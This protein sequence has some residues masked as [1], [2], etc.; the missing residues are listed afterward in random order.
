M[1]AHILHI[2]AGRAV[3]GSHCDPLALGSKP[4]IKLERMEHMRMNQSRTRSKWGHRWGI[5]A[6][7]GLGLV[8][9]AACGG[10]ETSPGQPTA[11]AGVGGTPPATAGTPAAAG[12]AAPAGAAGTVATGGRAGTGAAG[13]RA[14][15]AGTAAAGTGS[16]TAGSAAVSAGTGGAAGA[17]G[18][19]GEAGAAGAAGAAGTG[20]G[21]V[22]T[23]GSCLDG[24]T[25]FFAKGK[26][27]FMQMRS[28]MINFWKPMVPAGCK[29]PVI[30][31]ANGTGASCSNYAAS[32]ERMASHGFLAA[33][34]ENANTG[35]GT[36]GLEAL[37]TAVTM[38]PDLVD[39]KFGSTGHSQGGQASFVVLQFA[40]KEFGPDAK[41]AGLAMQPASGFGE[42]PAGGWQSIYRMIKSPML[43]F[44]G[45]GTDGL[46]SQA[47]VQDA[48][49]ELDDGIEAYHWTKQGGAH[50]PVPNGEE[51]QLS[52]AW[53]RWK[54]LGD[55]KACAAFKAIPMMD[56]TWEE[57]AVQNAAPCM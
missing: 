32:L 39:K 47:W 13:A 50:I 43:M 49:T 7:A 14:G 34:Y 33:C 24:D 46:V 29:V 15:T 6:L 23:E 36:Q 55:Q 56:R 17:A 27:Q 37:K 16:G 5:C 18:A 35:A 4:G 9:L 3:R 12:S 52:I 51:M 25:D 48:F 22:P 42:R 38:F 20:G 40:E 41:Y 45:R 57:V 10:D 53:F 26:F 31:L 8:S 21:D 44:S 1:Y 28:G 30:H 19:A 11:M 54:L 2:A